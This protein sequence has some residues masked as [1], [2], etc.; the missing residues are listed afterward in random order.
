M[1][2]RWD[3]LEADWKQLRAKMAAVQK[4]HG[5]EVDPD[6]VVRLNVGGKLMDIRR[7]TLTICEGSRLEALFS[8]RWEKAL[9]R[10][11]DGRSFIDDN[12]KCFKK[13]LASLQQLRDSP[14]GQ[15][16]KPPKMEADQQP[17][18]ERM[19]EHYGLRDALGYPALMKIPSSIL[20]RDIS[21]R[22]TLDAW[23]DSPA[24]LQLLYRCVGY[25]YHNLSSAACVNLPPHT[26]QGNTRW[27]ARG[28]FSS[29]L[30]QPGQNAH[31]H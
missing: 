29:T 12:P 25:G 19:L 6:G 21:L 18:S 24:S 28:R 4:E 1:A 2:A 23:L 15:H 7:S 30:R 31:C 14:A 5:E 27:V 9:R 22:A 10:D 17:Y 26:R 20:S 11:A 3:T 13:L 16:K 8:G